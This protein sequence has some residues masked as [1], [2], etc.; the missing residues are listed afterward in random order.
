M[1][2]IQLINFVVLYDNCDDS[3]NHDMSTYCSKIVMPQILTIAHLIILSTTLIVHT[4][5]SF[6]GINK[7][8]YIVLHNVQHCCIRT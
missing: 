1:I 6:K 8:K 4:A 7:F 5:I 2:F 3:H